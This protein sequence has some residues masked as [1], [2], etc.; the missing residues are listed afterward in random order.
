MMTPEV[1]GKY[2]YLPAGKIPHRL[3][4]LDDVGI[5]LFDLRHLRLNGP[6]VYHPLVIMQYALS[7]HSLGIDGNS[8]AWEIFAQ[9]AQWLEDNVVEEAQK[10]FVVW[11]FSFSLRTPPVPAPWISGM[12]Q[13]K[14]LSVFARSFQRTGSSRTADVAQRAARSFLYTVREGGVITRPSIGTCFI[15]EVAYSPAI[16]ILNGCLCALVGLFEHLRV[17]PDSQFQSVFEA[18]VEGVEDLLPA[19]DTGYWSRYSLGVRWHLAT[20]HYHTIHVRQLRYLGN[21]LDCRAFSSYADRWEEYEGSRF[22]RLRH[23]FVESLQVNANRA[24]TIVPLNFLK[25]RN[26]DK[27][28]VK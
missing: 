9:C 5:P 2:Y 11:P 13:G 26:A 10:R 3:G 25:Y 20:V 27:P 4:P 18:C 1:L 22:N 15:E 23:R 14:A 16:H 19:F 6:T 8:Q 7:Q 21:L 28:Q 12:A 17:F 24:M